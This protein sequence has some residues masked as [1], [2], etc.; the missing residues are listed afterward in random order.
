MT[1][2]LAGVFAAL[3]ALLLEIILDF[4]NFQFN[5]SDWALYSLIIYAVIEE[6]AKYFAIRRKI[7]LADQLKSVL[8]G[9]FWLGL[10]FGLLELGILSLNKN[11]IY[12]GNIASII[13]VLL[14]HL[15][16][17]LLTGLFLAKLN[18]KGR[19][20]FLAILPALMLH[21]AFNYSIYTH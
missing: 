4:L 6:L 3:G 17:V 19:Y 1:Y 10:G 7:N 13:A 14:V 16:T 8:Y 12:A 9:C 18:H 5:F 2:F 15:A 21:L 20:A 11:A